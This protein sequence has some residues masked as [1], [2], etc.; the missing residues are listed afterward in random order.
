[1]SDYVDAL[2]SSYISCRLWAIRYIDA[3]QEEIYNVISLLAPL[4]VS[5]ESLKIRRAAKDRLYELT[6]GCWA[7]E[8]EYQ[9]YQ[10]WWKLNSSRT[11]AEWAGE[12]INYRNPK[13]L[14]R[15]KLHL[16]KNGLGFSR[17]R[18]L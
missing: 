2:S 11:M 9:G 14:P 3:P 7:Y 6:F 17:N 1:F 18:T 13:R 12:A 5:T 15:R 10:N 8:E 4:F 16:C